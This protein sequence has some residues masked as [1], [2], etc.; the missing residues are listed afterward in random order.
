MAQYFPPYYCDPHATVSVE[1]S[2]Q[3][4]TEL[5]ELPNEDIAIRKALARLGADNIDDCG[6]TIDGCC[7]ITDEWWEKIQ[8]VENPKDLLGLN[9]LL[10]TEDVFM[11]QKPSKSIFYREISEWLRKNEFDFSEKDGCI[12]VSIDGC[13]EAKIYN[14][15]TIAALTKNV[16]DE[17][18]KILQAAQKI[19]KYCSVYEKAALLKVSG[20]V[21]DYRSL[22]EFNETV[23]VAK[24]SEQNGLEFVT[25]DRTYDGNAVCQ[26]NYYS[27]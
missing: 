14:S 18:H 3:E 17:Y 9:N 13:A 22:A 8:E 10:K 20:L 2:Y 15:G 26:G 25:W 19:Y 23:L 27:D 1:V 7:D 16:G 21:G 5:I 12:I 4:E 6:I 11:K 24:Y